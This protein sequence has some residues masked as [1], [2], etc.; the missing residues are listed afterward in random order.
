MEHAIRKANNVGLYLE[1]DKLSNVQF[2]QSLGFSIT[3]QPVLLGTP[4][5]LMLNDKL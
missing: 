4:T 1:T 5:W 3:A 2:Y